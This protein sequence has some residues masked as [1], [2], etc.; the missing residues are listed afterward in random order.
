MTWTHVK[1]NWN[2]GL[3]EQWIMRT[4]NAPACSL[5]RGE[6]SD[7]WVAS[8]LN[9]DGISARV[10]HVSGRTLEQAKAA[11]ETELRHMGWQLGEQL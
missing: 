11:C 3:A 1:T 5:R 7:S 9:V 10:L 2:T 6:T 8:L 4:R